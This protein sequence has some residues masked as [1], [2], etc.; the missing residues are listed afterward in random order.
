M[1]IEAQE[2]IRTSSGDSEELAEAVNDPLW[3]LDDVISEFF[4]VALSTECYKRRV[5]SIPSAD[6]FMRSRE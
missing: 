1:I 2:F 5:W 6:L 4:L 3:F